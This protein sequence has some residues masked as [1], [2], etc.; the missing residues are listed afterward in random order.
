MNFDVV[1]R[2]KCSMHDVPRAGCLDLLVLANC[3][4]YAVIVISISHNVCVCVCV[5]T[6]TVST[7]LRSCRIR[8]AC[9]GAQH[10]SPKRRFS[11]CKSLQ[12][13]SET[14]FKYIYQMYI[15]VT[16]IQLQCW[17]LLQLLTRV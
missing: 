1:I 7:A 5:A 16:L 8:D 13:K 12:W 3:V 11:P 10:G 15:P 14:C 17:G 4:T 9:R 2:K 6:I